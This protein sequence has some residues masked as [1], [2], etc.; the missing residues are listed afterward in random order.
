MTA[1]GEPPTEPLTDWLGREEVLDRFEAAWQEHGEARIADFLP[2]GGWEQRGPLLAELIKIDLEYRWG[3]GERRHVEDYAAEFPELAG[4]LRLLGELLAAEIAARRRLGEP[5]TAA[6]LAARF[7]DRAD[8]LDREAPPA[9]ATGRLGRYELRGEVGRGSFATVYRAWDPGLGREVAVKVPRPEFLADPAGRERALREARSAARLRHPAIIPL[10]EAGQ[11]GE[12]AYLVYEFIAGPTLAERLRQGR[13]GPRPA[14]EWAARLADALDAAHRAGLV[15]RDVKPANVIL[16]PDGRPLLADFGLALQT[17]ALATLTQTGDVLGTPAYMSPEQAAG[18][19]HLADGRSDVYGLGVVL[20][21]MLCG[22]VPFS[23]S[24]AT[25]LHQLL[26]HDPPPPRGLRPDVPR[27]LETVCLK[28]LAREPARRYQT[29][30]AFADDLRRFLD[31]RPVHARR[32][33]PAG[34]LALWCRRNPALAVTLTAAA[35]ALVLAVAGVAFHRVLAER[36]RYQAER[37]QALAHLYR[38]LVGE[39][40]ALR[41]ARLNGYRV[42]AWDRLRQALELDTP[43]RDPDALRQEAVAGLGDFVGL[44]PALWE[45]PGGSRWVVAAAVDAD[46]GHA[47]FGLSDGLVQV[48]RLADGAEVACW[49]AHPAGVYAL[50]AGPR[51]RFVSADDAG[52]V[53]V[54]ERACDGWACARTL[55]MAPSARPGH[56]GAAS[57]TLTADGRRLFGC[58]LG[59]A[60]V[61]VWDLESGAEGEPFRAGEGEMFSS[62][63]VTADGRRLAA[64]AHVGGLD[65]LRV[66]DLPDRRELPAVPTRVGLVGHVTFSPDGRHLACAGTGGAAVFDPADGFRPRLFLPDDDLYSVTFTPDGRWLAVPSSQRGTVQLWDVH[67]NREAALLKHPSEPH[68]VVVGGG[69][70][71]AVSA[72]HAQVWSLAGS[73]ERV[74]LP[75]H[76]AAVAAV[77]FRPDGRLLASASR[78]H[79]V[80]LWDV[81][82]G[83]L[84]RTLDDFHEPVLAVAFAPDGRT[85]AT[86][87]MGGSVRLWDVADDGS[88]RERASL[89][90]DTNTSLASLAFS[91]D[92]ELLAA[93]TGT[94]VQVWRRTGPTFAPDRKFPTPGG[95][96]GLE[97]SPDGRWL[98]WSANESRNLSVWDRQADQTWDLPIG[99]PPVLS[100]SADGRL[101]VRVKSGAAE[102]WDLS[103]R[104]RVADLGRLEMPAQ[105]N[106]FMGFGMAWNATGEW[107]AVQYW[108]VTV[109]DVPNR[110]LLF[111]LPKDPGAPA[112]LAWAP[113]G[114]RLAVGGDDGGLVVW[115]VPRV[116]AQLRAVGLDW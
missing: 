50:T 78:D 99:A 14:A 57:L 18:R 92:G 63:A 22:R 32:L 47:Y 74:A 96:I 97:F 59:A 114:Q 113:N 6:E 79:T 58:P 39:A 80:R 24:P 101:M 23:G 94:G 25:V 29:A 9:P 26:H 84:L 44:E 103:R 61:S 102:V 106:W 71:L 107:L 89:A 98:A 38:S 86:G 88:A 36:D 64:A 67:A 48:R 115:D 16:G 40:R 65:R 66:W 110:R 76:R 5:P 87:E 91:A 112:C 42:Q 43:L 46:A 90:H 35:A 20:F 60:G 45:R 93:G 19:S 17:D 21:E 3:R 13:P 105:G 95:V 2:P 73:G 4:P 37:E 30:G 100:F 31:R 111:Q 68:T 82:T 33:G 55:G 1:A 69:A 15:H 77:A 12:T 41:L 11:D 70:L 8:A 27:D 7:G 72:N 28:A 104:A 62:A 83:R 109:W 116:R 56:V 52:R 85:L 81:A 49:P 10:Y 108:G 54:W 34:R 75:G 51:G 53:K